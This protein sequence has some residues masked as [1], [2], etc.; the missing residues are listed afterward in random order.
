MDMCLGVKIVINLIYD[1]KKHSIIPSSANLMA[2]LIPD[3]HPLFIYFLCHPYFQ[4]NGDNVS[5]VYLF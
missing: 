3:Y 4:A 1:S 2:S 5:Y